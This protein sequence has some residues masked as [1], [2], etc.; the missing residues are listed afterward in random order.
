MLG[1]LAWRVSRTKEVVVRWRSVS[2][3]KKQVA[4]QQEMATS[5][6]RGCLARTLATIYCPKRVAELWNRLLREVVELPSLEAF[7]RC[8][9]EVLREVV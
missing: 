2:S 1:A 9:D 8:V 6:A 3:P 5:C 7:K 4:G